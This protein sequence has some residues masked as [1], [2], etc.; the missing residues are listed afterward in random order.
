MDLSERRPNKWW[1]ESD[2][3]AMLALIEQLDLVHE[4]DKK[5]QRNDSHFRRLRYSL[6]KQDIHFTVN[7]IRNRWKSLK[8]KY[9]KIKMAGY[10]SPAAR[11]STIEAFRYFRMLD[12]MLAR[13]ARV[14]APDQGIADGHNM[15][16]LTPLDMEDHTDGDVAQ[17]DSVAPWQDSL[18]PALDGEGDETN[19]IPE[20][21]N[22]STPGWALKSEEIMTLGL[23]GEYLYPVKSEPHSVPSL[24]DGEG[25]SDPTSCSPEDEIGTCEDT[26]TLILQQL[27]I[28]NHQLGEQLAEQRAFHCSMLGMMDRQIEV[29]EQL[30]NFSTGRHVKTE[31]EESDTPISQQVH[32][33]LVRILRGVEQVQTQGHQPCSCK[34]SP[35]QPT[36]PSWTVSLLEVHKGSPSRDENSTSD[37]P[38]PQ[39]SD[40]GR[41]EPQ[42]PYPSEQLPPSPQKGVLFN[43]L[44]NKCQHK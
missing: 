14:G 21:A 3:F 42:I 39:P 11:L 28:L 2:T 6:A 20:E 15:V 12:R 41:P 8:H 13:R 33:S 18:A 30:S 43:G 34:A 17:P 35:S 27:T 9:R 7:Q 1:T 40:N 38:N 5:R 22:V 25:S 24:H 36:S 19:A 4:L 32:N 16:V 29:L 37:T 44:S 31:P 26:S 23:S 10:R